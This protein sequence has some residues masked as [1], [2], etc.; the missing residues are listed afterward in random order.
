MANH[1]FGGFCGES[2]CETNLF[3]LEWRKGRIVV[4]ITCMKCGNDAEFDYETLKDQLGAA[5]PH[6]DVPE[7]VLLVQ[8][9][10]A[11]M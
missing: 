4:V 3:R 5:P 1:K 2:E 8:E 6:L 10:N 9:P 7:G 11:I